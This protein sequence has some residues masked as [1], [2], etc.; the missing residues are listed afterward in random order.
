VKK[1]SRQRT[2]GAPKRR[3]RRSTEQ[4]L[5]LI[6]EAA[7]DEFERNG[8]EGATTAAIARKAGVTEALIFSN[9]GSKARLFHDSIFKPLD[10]HF[11][12]FC[13]T[14]LVEPGDTE[15]WKQET[16]QYIHE[17]QQFIR[18]HSRM[19]RSV[20]ATQMY[21]SDAAQSV[22]Q[23]EG[24]DA[25]FSRAAAVAMTRLSGKPKIDP[26]LLARVSFAT[27]LA[28]I[29]FK[30]WL[31]PKGLASEEAISAALSDFMMEGL[32]AN[33]ASRAKW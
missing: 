6:L 2:Q 15:G 20:V 1:N 19:L 23:I 9:F 30:D 8:Y 5:D 10:Q 18:R 29:L 4:V 7:C 32:Q 27:L 28:C 21:A 17:L 22:S 33:A 31:F 24:L 14:H 25:F 16:R 12:Q 13:A 11:V 26:K 3:Q